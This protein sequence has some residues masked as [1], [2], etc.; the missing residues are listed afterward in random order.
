MNYQEA[1][2]FIINHS[3]TVGIDYSLKPMISLCDKMGNPQ[4][5]L[6]VIHIAGT[7]G[8]GSIGTAIC[9]MLASCGY[10]VGRYLSPTLFSYRER[11]QRISSVEGNIETNY[12]SKEEVASGLTRICNLSKEQK[13]QG[14]EMP[15]AFEM[16]TA[17][18]FYQ[19]CQWK[20]D[21]AVIETGMGGTLDATNVVKNPLLCVF[22]NIG[23]DHKAFLGE[24]ISEIASGKAGIIKEK[25]S[26]ISMEQREEVDQVLRSTCENKKANYITVCYDE[27]DKIKND[28]KGNCFRYEQ[29]EYEVQ[30]TGKYQV[31]NTAVAIKSLLVIKEKGYSK[32]NIKDMKQGLLQTHMY[33]RFDI[34]NSIPLLIVDGAHNPQGAKALCDSLVDKYPE[35]T[36]LFV[37]GVFADKDRQGILQEIIPLAKEIYTVTPPGPR[38]LSASLLADE[39]QKKFNFNKVRDFA[40]VDGALRKALEDGSDVVVCGSLSYLH[41]VYGYLKANKEGEPSGNGEKDENWK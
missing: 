22:S 21:F 10:M 4:D 33:G 14:G 35:R 31:Y 26:V 23:V 41:M 18:A 16:E 17:L 13:R 12:I 30:L 24:S 39:I 1:K 38:G 3:K 27:I 20:V 7:N 19:M 25:A 11:I 2:E 34:V 28:A 37:I 29:E 8:K 36:F 5:D 32:I 40:T 6:V 15:S 9:N